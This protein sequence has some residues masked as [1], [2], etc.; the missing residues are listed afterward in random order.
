[1]ERV[2][3]SDIA[4]TP[5]VKSVQER[6]GSRRSYASMEQKGGRHY[7]VTPDLE[8]FIA[9]IDS[10]YLGDRQ[11]QG[12]ALHQASGRPERVSQGPG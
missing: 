12:T 2:V 1:M 3:V 4:F 6:L 5:A 10:F 7:T 8:K 9:E 11:R